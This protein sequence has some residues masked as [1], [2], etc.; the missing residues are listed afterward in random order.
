MRI[1]KGSSSSF[2]VIATHLV[3]TGPSETDRLYAFRRSCAMLTCGGESG[4]GARLE[5]D[6]APAA[7]TGANG[8]GDRTCRASEEGPG[9]PR[10]QARP[11]KS[12]RGR[13]ENKCQ[14]RLQLVLSETT[15]LYVTHSSI[16]SPW[17]HSCAFRLPCFIHSSWKRKVELKLLTSNPVGQRGLQMPMTHLLAMLL[18]WSS[19]FCRYRHTEDGTPPWRTMGNHLFRRPMT[20]TRTRKPT[21][22]LMPTN[23]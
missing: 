11:A 20:T 12:A 23:V 19:E 18:R 13:G 7:E 21:V 3:M 22:R 14:R 1:R 17:Q 5:R 6:G 8:E 16:C 4:L 15:V 9:R 2:I 10:R